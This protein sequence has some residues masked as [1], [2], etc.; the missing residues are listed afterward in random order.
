[1]PKC[2]KHESATCIFITKMIEI[3]LDYKNQRRGKKCHQVPLYVDFYVMC[4]HGSEYIRKVSLLGTSP[5]TLFL[6]DLGY[7]CDSFG[8]G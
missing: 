8:S 2:L 5:D 7:W 1:M 4:Q 6:W 3:K